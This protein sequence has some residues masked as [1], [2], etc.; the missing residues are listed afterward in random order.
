MSTTE[1]STVSHSS[2]FGIMSKGHGVIL[3]GHETARVAGA[4]DGVATILAVLQQAALDADQDPGTGLH[5]DA[6]VTLGLLSAAAAC[7]EF[8]G[9][10]VDLGGPLGARAAHGTPAYEALKSAR[11]AVAQANQKEAG[12]G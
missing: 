11:S 10:I 7:T 9:S 5:L 6:R 3:T 4:L 8:V 1:N 12:H 2:A